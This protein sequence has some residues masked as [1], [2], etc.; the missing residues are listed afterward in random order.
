MCVQAFQICFDYSNNNSGIII[1]KIVLEN[2]M[3]LSRPRRT[4]AKRNTDEKVLRVGEKLRKDEGEVYEEGEIIEVLDRGESYR[5]KWSYNGETE[6]L[7]KGGTHDMA[8]YQNNFIAKFN[9]TQEAHFELLINATEINIVKEKDNFIKEAICNNDK[10]DREEEAFEYSD[11]EENEN[12]KSSSL[13][14]AFRS[15]TSCSIAD[16]ASFDG[17][18]DQCLDISLLM[19]QS[20]RLSPSSKAAPVNYLCFLF[21]KLSVQTQCV[22]CGK[23]DTDTVCTLCQLEAFLQD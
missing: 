14:V 4:T 6:V 7:C 5:V 1:Y 11:L 15:P 8:L 21:E 16:T 9:K 19:E 13:M 18:A 10:V 2:T 17:S 20:P 22:K 23:E 12:G 3:L